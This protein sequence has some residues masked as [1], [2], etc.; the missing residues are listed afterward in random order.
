[1]TKWVKRAVGLLIVLVL[2]WL[3][4]PSVYGWFHMM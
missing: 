3:I 2:A 1:M 4:V